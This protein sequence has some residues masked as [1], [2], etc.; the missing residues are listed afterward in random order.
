MRRRETTAGSVLFDKGFRDNVRSPVSSKPVTAANYVMP[1]PSPHLMD[2]NP[3]RQAAPERSRHRR[4][5]SRQ[6]IDPVATHS[7]PAILNQWDG[8]PKRRLNGAI[9]PAW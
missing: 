9:D 7:S 8:Y 2:D 4:K 5:V 6:D 1:V 3:Y